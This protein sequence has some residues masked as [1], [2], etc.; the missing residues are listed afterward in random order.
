MWLRLRSRV[1]SS[2]KRQDKT[3][4][5][6]SKT[7]LI[8]QKLIDYEKINFRGDGHNSYGGTNR[9]RTE[10]QQGGSRS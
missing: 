5:N 8:K 10:G 2:K 3:I 6:N 7:F 9:K 4:N 1:P